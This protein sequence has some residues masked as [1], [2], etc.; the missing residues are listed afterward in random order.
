VV[1]FSHAEIDTVVRNLPTDKAPG[2][3]G[4]NTD[5]LKKC[6]SIVCEDFYSLCDAFHSENICLQSINGSHITLIPKKD[7]ALK[8]SDYGPIS[9]LNTYVK[10][11]TKLLANW[12]QLVL[13]SLIHKNQYGFIKN[14]TIQDC[15][16]WALEYLHICHQSK[17]VIIGL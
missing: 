5:F 9:L 4:F 11:I 10:L 6:W 14:R 16:A 15:L 7:D 13:P 17:K 2:P 12:L 8:V 3:V 1:S